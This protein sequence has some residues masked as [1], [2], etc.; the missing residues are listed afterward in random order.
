MNKK[1]TVSIS[2]VFLA[3]FFLSGCS[4]QVNSQDNNVS[5]NSLNKQEQKA[6]VDEVKVI[7]FHGSRRCYSCKTIEKYAK[8]TV[9]EYFQPELRDGKISFQSINVEEPQNRET[10]E[11]YQ[12]RGSSLYINVIRDGGDNI[13]EVTRVWRLVGNEQAFKNYLKQKLESYLN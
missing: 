12:A 2:F 9:E 5:K 8:E 6:E 11:K 7:D 4:S 10:V 3:L 1:I 13:S